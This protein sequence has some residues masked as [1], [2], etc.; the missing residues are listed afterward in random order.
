MLRKYVFSFIPPPGVHVS[1]DDLEEERGI[2]GVSG[3]RL[4]VLG[5][6]EVLESNKTKYS[7]PGCE[8]LVCLEQLSTLLFSSLLFYIQ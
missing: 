5:M 3:L 7:T 8:F 2:P 1:E 6:G 4:E